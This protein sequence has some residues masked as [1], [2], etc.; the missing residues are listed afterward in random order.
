M[1][2]NAQ[3]LQ[4][5][6]LSYDIANQF[7]TSTLLYGNVLNLS[8]PGSY[9]EWPS[10]VVP[11]GSDPQ[12]AAWYDPIVHFGPDFIDPSNTLAVKWGCTMPPLGNFQYTEVLSRKS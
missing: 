3:H 5:T 2:G 6:W 1:G 8:E 11:Q 12:A 10:A 4:A 7:W 9:R